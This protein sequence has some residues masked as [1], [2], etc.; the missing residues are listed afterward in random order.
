MGG[1]LSGTY[2]SGDGSCVNCP[3]ICISCTGAK[4]CTEC[5]PGYDLVS[6]VCQKW[7]TDSNCFDC[8]SNSDYCKECYAGYEASDGKCVE[9]LTCNNSTK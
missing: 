6:G 3:S 5:I 4:L 8:S 9:D 1:C 2:R 7:C